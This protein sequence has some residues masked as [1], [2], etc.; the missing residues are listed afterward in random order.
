MGTPDLL[1][2]GIAL[3]NDYILVTNNQKHFRPVGSLHTA[4]WTK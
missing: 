3:A 2:A 4:N 1:I